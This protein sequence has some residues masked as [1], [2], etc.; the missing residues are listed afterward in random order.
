[1]GWVVADDHDPPT[2]KRTRSALLAAGARQP[3]RRYY[4]PFFRQSRGD[5]IIRV[6]AAADSHTDD[7]GVVE[8]TASGSG[9]GDTGNENGSST[10]EAKVTQE[11]KRRP[12]KR[13]NGLLA[14]RFQHPFDLVGSDGLFEVYIE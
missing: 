3:S 12:R 10:E 4:L 9:A 11:R 7:Y 13:F 8:G 2:K 6:E 5:R 14:D 1:M